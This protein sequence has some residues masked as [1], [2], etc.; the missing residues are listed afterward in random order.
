VPL[1]G[2]LFKQ[3]QKVNNNRELMVF[4]T[5]RIVTDEYLGRNTLVPEGTGSTDS[6][7]HNF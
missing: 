5:P 6:N 2:G 4:V 3:E 7:M 1:L